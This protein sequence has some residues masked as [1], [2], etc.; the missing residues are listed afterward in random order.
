MTEQTYRALIEEYTK[1][2]NQKCKQLVNEYAE[3]N[4]KYQIG[5]ILQN[6]DIIIRVERIQGFS[7]LVSPCIYYSGTLLNKTLLPKKSGKTGGMFE[8]DEPIQIMQSAT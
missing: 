3:S 8:N 1:R 4:A 5:D 6:E 7:G 2:Y